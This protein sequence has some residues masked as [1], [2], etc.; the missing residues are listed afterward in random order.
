MFIGSVLSVYAE[1]TK[2]PSVA[3][4]KVGMNSRKNITTLGNLPLSSLFA[5]APPSI[6]NNEDAVRIINSAMYIDIA[7]MPEVSYGSPGFSSAVS[8]ALNNSTVAVTFKAEAVALQVVFENFIIH[9]EV[10]SSR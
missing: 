9:L 5:N 7:G 2:T 10:G 1:E 4:A 8:E 3:V 6:K